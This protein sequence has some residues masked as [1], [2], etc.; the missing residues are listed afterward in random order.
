[1]LIDA[2]QRFGVRVKVA[3]A[4]EWLDHASIEHLDTVP[5]EDYP[6]LLHNFDI[7]LV[8]LVDNRFNRA[9]SDLKVLE[10]AASGIPAIASPCAYSDTP[11]LQA[12][13][14]ADWMRHIGHLVAD[15]GERDRL[16]EAALA[17]AATRTIE[18]NAGLWEAAYAR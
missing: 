2:A 12:R 6:A 5:I 10:L 15:K 17:W 7:G 3:G 11:A 1:M 16:R 8:P 18:A 14:Y 9:K 13:S 4:S